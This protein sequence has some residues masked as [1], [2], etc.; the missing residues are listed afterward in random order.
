ML[1]EDSGTLPRSSKRNFALEG[2]PQVHTRTWT[3]SRPAVAP[4]P[5]VRVEDARSPPAQME[6][7]VRGD[8]GGKHGVPAGAVC[9][10][11][12]RRQ[13]VQGGGRRGW[14]PRA[15]VQPVMMN[16]FQELENVLAVNDEPLLVMFGVGPA[17]TISRWDAWCRSLWHQLEDHGDMS[18]VTR[19]LEDYKF[20]Y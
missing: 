9:E 2:D 14:T 11:Q 12:Q 18:L 3:T 19:L 20:G 15:C 8:R 7:R 13:Q 1:E 10:E 4:R 17:P 6:Q 16:P 5:R